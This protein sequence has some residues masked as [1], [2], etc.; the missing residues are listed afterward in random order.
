MEAQIHAIDLQRFMPFLATVAEC[1]C[2][3]T[4]F[5][6]LG[7]VYLNTQT[8]SCAALT[9]LSAWLIEQPPDWKNK[10]TAPQ[11]FQLPKNHLLIRINFELGANQQKIWLAAVFNEDIDKISSKKKQRLECV[12]QTISHCIAENYLTSLSIIG[13]TEELA[14]RYEELNLLY[15]LD[16]N[17]EYLSSKNEHEALSQLLNN[18]TDYLA[19]DLLAIFIPEQNSLISH[20]INK[21]AQSDLDRILAYLQGPLLH[22]M[23]TKNE[24]TIINRESDWADGN[25][26]IPYKIIATPLLK[27]SGNLAG[28]LMLAK[29]IKANDFTNSDKRLS[30]VLAIEAAMLIKAR[31]DSL[32][33]LLNRKGFY[34]KLE[35]AF[36]QVQ[37]Q[38]RM[39]S[40]VFFDIDQFK[41]INETFSSNA[42]D[43]LLTQVGALIKNELA[44]TD[45]IARLG[46]DEFALLL[47]DYS[48]I[49]AQ[50][51]AETIRQIINQFRFVYELKM[52]SV[53]LSIGVT[54]VDPAANN[55][56]ELLSNAD[57]ACRIAKENG[58]N[59]VHVYQSS[60]QELLLHEDQMQWISRINQAL[61]EQRFELYRQ[62][63]LPLSGDTEQ[64]HYELLI[65]L[66]DEHN[67][68][69]EP[70]QFIPAAE[71]YGLMTK[72]DRWVVHSALTKM[73][74]I[75]AVNADSTLACSINLCG[76][77]FCEQGFLEYLIDQVQQSGI[78]PANICLEITE[79]VAVSN[80]S[81]TIEFMQAVK[82]I[83]CKFSLDDFGSG[84][85]SFTYLKNLP[86]DYLK[87][88]GYF[89][90]TILDNKIDYAM[91]QAIN[92]IGQVMGLKTIAEFVE[93]DAILAELKKIGVD[94]GQGYGI[95]KPEPFIT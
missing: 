85:S 35:S 33:E 39:Y 31:R 12:L 79:T 36:T 19:V 57:L 50:Q 74:E 66:R 37:S 20:S 22:W 68:L 76:Q 2:A 27:E 80:L 70:N 46:A 32:T 65:R 42:G 92:Q 45:V 95:G 67:R 73:A 82:K 49:K 75:Y 94:Y 38:G 48:L 4:L 10:A 21:V 26:G 13:M 34:E 28:I 18:C 56:S 53:A 40:L 91:V 89:V 14:V 43:K 29:T 83:G 24:T 84:M 44:G 69:I 88:D 87:I 62:R 7:H 81:Q 71:R 59:Q 17:K 23:K 52:H 1:E 3:M 16:N 78:P 30:E 15:G 64:E 90:K 8:Q 86:V 51:K 58:G 55:I 54:W 25:A 93:N 11:Y 61:Q 47:A 77:S 63:I 9:I 60:D 41:L 6:N 72:L 5:D